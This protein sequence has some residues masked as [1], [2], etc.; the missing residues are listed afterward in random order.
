[1]PPD[2]PAAQRAA[3]VFAKHEP[4]GIA[5]VAARWSSDADGETFDLR[6]SPQQMAFSLGGD[7]LAMTDMSGEARVHPTYLT[8]DRVSATFPEGTGTL[9]G[10]VGFGETSTAIQF[11][12]TGREIGTTSRALLPE[13]ALAVLDALD[14]Q[15]GYQVRSASLIHRP[16]THDDPGTEFKGVI[17]LQDAS[18]DLGVAVTDF[19]GKI[20][21]IVKRTPQRP[22]P[23]VNLKLDAD[24]LR[25]DERLVERLSLRLR[26]DGRDGAIRITDLRGTMYG[27]IIIGEG[28]IVPGADGWYGARL[29]MHEVALEPFLNP[30]DPWEPLDATD[31]GED[32]LLPRPLR[33][34]EHS[35]L[36]SASLNLEAKL[37]SPGRRSGRG[38]IEVHDASLFDRPLSLALLQASNLR[39]PQSSSLDRL[40]SRFIIDDDTVRFDSLSFNARFPNLTI[41]GTGT[42]DWPTRSLDLTMYNR[43][44]E[45]WQLGPITDVFNSIK[46]E[47]LVIRVEGP[48][49]NPQAR[50]ESFSGLRRTWDDLFGRA[51]ARPTAPGEV[52]RD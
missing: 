38:S 34:R 6:F 36:V 37:D 32:W 29:T 16:D 39:L 1:V 17:A 30:G 20:G 31:E 7:R 11:E 22:T 47:L 35:G 24:D 25:L 46:D 50:V 43:N 2:H 45:G 51:Q 27:G 23:E 5:D 49:Q 3:A 4:D 8:L 18:A 10:V 33:R 48:A 9:S 52:S 12:A 42:M 26:G 21:V 14:L 15:T 44:P 28:V 40:S 19:N 41:T 13:A